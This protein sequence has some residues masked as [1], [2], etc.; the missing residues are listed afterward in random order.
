[1]NIAAVVPA[2]IGDHHNHVQANAKGFSKLDDLSFKNKQVLKLLQELGL[3]K[4]IFGSF[5]QQ[6]GKKIGS[7]RICEVLQ[8]EKQDIIKAKFIAETEYEIATD[9]YFSEGVGTLLFRYFKEDRITYDNMNELLEK[10]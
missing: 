7:V 1:M 2:E 3:K 8:K 9:L 5:F 6:A 10:L 4:V